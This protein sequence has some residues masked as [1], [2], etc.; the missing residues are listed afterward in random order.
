[1]RQLPAIAIAKIC[2]DRSIVKEKGKP[3]DKVK[4]KKDQAVPIEYA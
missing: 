2:L 1:M 4:I 3:M